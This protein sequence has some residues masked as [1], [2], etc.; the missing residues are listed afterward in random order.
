LLREIA[1]PADARLVLVH[2]LDPAMFAR[3]AGDP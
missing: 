3:V 2:A 1:L